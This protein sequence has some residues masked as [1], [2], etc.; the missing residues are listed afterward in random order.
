M[1]LDRIKILL[2]IT[3]FLLTAIFYQYESGYDSFFPGSNNIFRVESRLRLE[4][5]EQLRQ[6]ATPFPLAEELGEN[7]EE[8]DRA[9]RISRPFVKSVLGY[10]NRQKRAVRDGIWADRDFFSV[11]Q[12]PLVYGK[13]DSLLSE[14]D[15]LVLSR[16]LAAQM[17]GS[18]N[19]IGQTVIFDNKARCRVTG[20]FSDLPSNSHL[21]F[22][23]VISREAVGEMDAGWASG[24]VFTYI[25]LNKGQKAG[26]LKDR[27]KSLLK[28]KAIEDKELSLTPLRNI[29]LS[30]NGYF[31]F[32]PNKERRPLQFFLVIAVLLLFLSTLNTGCRRRNKEEQSEETGSKK[33]HSSDLPP[34]P[35][36]IQRL[37]NPALSA[38]I[39]TAPAIVLT[40]LL[41][42]TF[43]RSLG[44]DIAIAFWPAFALAV[45]LSLIMVTLS[46][47]I[48]QSIRGKFLFGRK[49]PGWIP[50]ETWIKAL[51][52]MAAAVFLVFH[53]IRNEDLN[54]MRDGR[55]G[56][57]Q[58]NIIIVPFPSTDPEAQNRGIALKNEL[59]KHP[60]ITK[61]SFSFSTPFGHF[62]LARVS[63][64]GR[65]KKVPVNVTFAD[66]DFIDTYG[67]LAEKGSQTP[68]PSV[69]Q[70]SEWTCVTNES[71]A[72]RLA[73]GSLDFTQI[74]QKRIVFSD[75]NQPLV[76]AVVK[77][78]PFPSNKIRQ[79]PLS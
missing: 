7:F 34:S 38:L 35:G 4:D 20:V 66:A 3:F 11:F 63:L 13:T 47:F 39:S 45:F 37:T 73:E 5:G 28:N 53:V 33:T 70:T 10:G 67:M 17:F 51:I 48:Q 21:R 42:P 12:I 64:E 68:P 19:P 40:L 57:D 15:S 77:D 55:P 9:V 50:V 27:L 29:H 44:L 23:F 76:S 46:L 79:V 18:I 25:R 2:G 75:T 6:A 59:L 60:Q 72:A 16:E 32:G 65:E 61:A 31:E 43:G 78:F 69:H 8:V 36:L 49:R 22:S 14:P 56:F 30:G 74:T 54:Q 24:T 62:P 41:I 1:I 26:I 71:A 52:F 58:Q